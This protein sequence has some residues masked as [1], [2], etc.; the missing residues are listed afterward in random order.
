MTAWLIGTNPPQQKQTTQKNKDK[1]IKN[2]LTGKNILKTTKD[3]MNDVGIRTKT[4]E[5]V[6]KKEVEDMN[7][8]IKK[9]TYQWSNGV[10]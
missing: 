6:S 7:R 3:T 1:E 8:K 2:I 10:Q 5:S 9:K 4:K